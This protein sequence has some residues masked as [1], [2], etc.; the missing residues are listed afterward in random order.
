MEEIKTDFTATTT[1]TTATNISKTIT[2][3]ITET[4]NAGKQHSWRQ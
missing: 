2:T 4:A 3:R 1:I